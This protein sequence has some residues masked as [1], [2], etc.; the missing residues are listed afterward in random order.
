MLSELEQIIFRFLGPEYQ[1]WGESVVDQLTPVNKR[2]AGFVEKEHVLPG[3]N[4]TN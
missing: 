2:L 3:S 4:R 1:F